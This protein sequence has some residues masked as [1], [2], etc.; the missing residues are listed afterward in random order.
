MPLVAI[1]PKYQTYLD[2]QGLSEPARFLALPG[3]IV[4]GH[5]QRHVLQLTLGAGP[6]AL[7]VFLKKEHRVSWKDRLASAWAGFGLVSKS[8][9][10]A[11][12]LQAL[13]R[14]GIPCPE[15]I[16]AGEDDTGQAFLVVRERAGGVDLRHFLQ[17]TLPPV[18]RR[19]WARSLG[20]TLARLHAAGFN[21]P[22]LNSK[23]VLV[24]PAAGQICFLDWQR[25]RRRTR[26]SWR[27]RGRDLAALNATLAD[28]LASPRDRLV[29]LRA[30]CQ[31]AG[32][33]QG[34]PRRRL[35]RFIA[36]QSER[37]LKRRR[38]RDL[39]QPP[40]QTGVQSLIWLDGE[41]LCVTPEFHARLGGQ[42]P[43]WLK[44]AG[45]LE[46]VSSGR[47]ARSVVPL[48]EGRSA[49]LVCR[50]TDHP[51]SLLARLLRRRPPPCPELEQV[52]LLYRLQRYG[53]ATAKLLAFGRRALPDRTESF[54]LTEPPAESAGLLDWLADQAGQPLRPAER[55]RRWRLIREAAAVLQTI[56]AAG[57]ALDPA[58]HNPGSQ[59]G[60]LRAADGAVTV[61]VHHVEGLKRCRR[62]KPAPA[63]R[64]LARLFEALPAGL[65][66]R[67]EALRF[68][69][70]YLGQARLTAAAKRTVRR[71]LQR[72]SSPQRV[73]LWTSPCATRASCPPAA[74][75]RPTLPT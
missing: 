34:R 71:I 66:S 3:V 36:C 18:D 73:T 48:P 60:V 10:E 24:G 40:L 56:H 59:L 23:H 50:R 63:D 11:A 41:A 5:P 61:V 22:D 4:T 25:S 43:A 35:A 16:A 62:G 75:A 47:V 9:R 54:L 51:R 45:R 17:Q 7:P 31:A 30:Y 46:G 32:I 38:I 2:R 13:A 37:L 21:H 6:S 67:T 69:L 64:D 19:R 42:L 44:P 70:A 14:A 58:A 55:R 20:E 33:G 39:R 74:A 65:G 52:G 1:N 57:Y 68:L 29:C 49:N 28:D 72:T 15:W 26:P 27:C 8:R 53:I 12:T